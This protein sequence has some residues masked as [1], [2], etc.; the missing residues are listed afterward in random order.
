[1]KQ[2]EW[3]SSGPL[4]RLCVWR[5]ENADGARHESLAV[6][7]EFIMKVD[8]MAETCGGR[9]K[10]KFRGRTF[11]VNFGAEVLVDRPCQPLDPPTCEAPDLPWK[12]LEKRKKGRYSNDPKGHLTVVAQWAQNERGGRDGG[13]H[14]PIGGAGCRLR[15]SN[16]LP[17]ISRRIIQVGAVIFFFFFLGLVGAP[18]RLSPTLAVIG[19]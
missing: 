10:K 2:V 18:S 17:V 1:M 4:G 9:K 5:C 15:K 8:S 19:R 3:I 16:R 6:A 14:A 12:Q 7:V 11:G 13:K